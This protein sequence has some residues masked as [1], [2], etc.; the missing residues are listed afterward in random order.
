MVLKPVLEFHHI[1]LYL[2][3]PFQVLPSLLMSS[4]VELGVIDEG[5]IQNMQGWWYSRTGLRTTGLFDLV[6]LI[7][8]DFNSFTVLKHF[9]KV[10]LLLFFLAHFYFFKW[11]FWFNVATLVSQN[12]IDRNERR[13]HWPIWSPTESRLGSSIV[14]RHVHY[15]ITVEIFFWTI[16]S[17]LL[18][19]N[20]PRVAFVSFQDWCQWSAWNYNRQRLN[21]KL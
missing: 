11:T 15:C 17:V 14:W 5:D 8:L 20:L 10:V 9:L 6:V 7:F 1:S 16:A 19:G 21:E 4:W 3:H 18:E 12:N 13:A 2:T